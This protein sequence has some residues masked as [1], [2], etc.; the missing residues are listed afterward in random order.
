MCN[1]Y[2]PKLVKNNSVSGKSMSQ[3]IGFHGPRKC[4]MLYLLTQ[5]SD[6]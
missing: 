4:F 2:K 6:P 3:P 5:L 1:I